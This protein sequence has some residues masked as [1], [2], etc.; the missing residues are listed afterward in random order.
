M[1]VDYGKFVNEYCICVGIVGV[2]QV[3]CLQVHLVF[4]LDSKLGQKW[5]YGAL[6]ACIYA[7]SNLKWNKLTNWL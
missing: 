7:K 1:V 6:K 3:C 2:M 4:V 5:K